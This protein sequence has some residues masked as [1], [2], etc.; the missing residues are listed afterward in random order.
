MFVTTS[1]PAF[2]KRWLTSK[3]VTPAWG[4]SHLPRLCLPVAQQ[5][6]FVRRC[7][8][9]QALLP[10]LKQVDWEQLPLTLDEKKGCWRTTPL[11][12]YVGAV[13]VIVELHP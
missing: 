11:A 6:K 8:T 4:V 7:L 1:I 13:L 12:A 5:P 2:W 3:S 9:T 10:L